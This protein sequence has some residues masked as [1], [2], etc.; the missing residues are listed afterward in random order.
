MKG[1]VT[2]DLRTH[3]QVN[4]MRSNPCPLYPKAAPV[5]KLHGRVEAREGRPGLDCSIHLETPDYLLQLVV[6][7][8][9]QRG[10]AHLEQGTRNALN[11]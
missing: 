2:V 11:R 9:L 5:H 4:V 7:K 6:G 10:R 3:E 8:P 1:R